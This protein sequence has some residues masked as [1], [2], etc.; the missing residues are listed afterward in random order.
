[1]RVNSPTKQ[2][3]RAAV[4]VSIILIASV[5]LSLSCGHSPFLA[6]LGTLTVMLGVTLFAGSEI[7]GVWWG[8]LIDSRNK[9]SLSRFQLLIWTLIVLSAYLTAVFINFSNTE[10][11]DPLNVEIPKEMWVLMGISTASLLGTP[12]IHNAKEEA[13]DNPARLAKNDEPSEASWT[14]LVRGEEFEKQEFLDLGRVQMVFFTC[15]LAIA[16]CYAVARLFIGF[17]TNISGLPAVGESMVAL[18]GISHSGYLGGKVVEKN[19]RPEQVNR[20]KAAPS[21]E[22]EKK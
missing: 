2:L 20:P 21:S 3:I 13:S 12:L 19:P 6:W 7:K 1:M 5:V 9:M 4:F 15:V 10:N 14:D 8:C 22:G 18:L 17:D 11:L 16:Y